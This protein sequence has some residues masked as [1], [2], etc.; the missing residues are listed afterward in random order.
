[1]FRV[2]GISF[3]VDR[4]Y[5]VMQEMKLF[6]ED[7]MVTTRVMFFNNGEREREEAFKII[8]ELRKKNISSEMYYDNAKN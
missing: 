8:Q 7:I 6:P 3:G 1:M 4:I 2:I 5:D